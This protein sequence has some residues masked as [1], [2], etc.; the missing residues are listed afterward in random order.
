MD[1][2]AGDE[3]YWTYVSRILINTLAATKSD[4]SDLYIDVGTHQKFLKL[5]FHAVR[6]ENYAI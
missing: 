4:N 1:L 5:T 2:F 6:F 3:I